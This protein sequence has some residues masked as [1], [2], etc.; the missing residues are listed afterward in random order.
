MCKALEELKQDWKQEGILLG[1]EEG[2]LLG[3][4]EG[5]AL[6]KAEGK[7]EGIALG[8]A[9]ANEN[10]IK[11]MYKNGFDEAL[12]SK[13]LDLDIEYVKSVLSK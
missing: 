13:A 6:G 9:K 5:I 12:I 4:A 11:T 1:K 7:A 8:E 3:K 10:N 2:I